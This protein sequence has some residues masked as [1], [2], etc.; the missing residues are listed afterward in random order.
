MNS[1]GDF[2]KDGA[3]AFH[4]KHSL[5]IRIWHWTTFITIASSLVLVLLGSTMFRTGDNVSL[6]LEQLERKGAVVTKDQAWSVAHEYSDKLWMAHKW[7][8]YG[9]CFLLF[10]RFI[11]ELAQP[12]EEKMKLKIKRAMGFRAT[13]PA[14]KDERRHYLIV[15]EGYLVFYLL[16]LVMGLTGLGL[17]FEHSPILKDI[18]D[19]IKEV[20]SIVQYLIYT[21]IL[22]HLIGVVRADIGKY[23]GI[24]SGMIHGKK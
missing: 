5:A 8:G 18:Q 15:R 13:T 23:R 4:E 16:F 19:P 3:G 7:V 17:A 12:G 22:V 14:E 2:K 24:V 11:I 9:L 1:E 20:H 6:V 21:Y 10:S